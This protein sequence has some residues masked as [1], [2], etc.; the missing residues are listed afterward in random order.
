PALNLH[1]EVHVPRRVNDIDSMLD[2]VMLPE[3]GRRG[4]GD[5]DAALLFLFHPVH[6]GRALVHLADLVRDAR[7]EEHTLGG[8]G[9]TGINVRHD[10]DIAELTEVLLSHNSYQFSVFGFQKSAFGL[11]KTENRKLKTALPLVMRERFVRFG[12][13][14]RVLFLL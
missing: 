3:A 6:R 4:T 12:H 7:V 14:V 11:L 5:R 1:R 2:V 10:A 13:A 9:L 8:R